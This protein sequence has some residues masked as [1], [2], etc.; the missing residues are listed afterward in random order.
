MPAPIAAFKVSPERLLD[1]A[2]ASLDL[3]RAP[4][5]ADLRADLS[6]VG[7]EGVRFTFELEDAV[8]ALST[9]RADQLQ[10][11][12]ALDEERE[13]DRLLAE[14]GFRWLSRL[15][16]RARLAAAGGADPEGIFPHRLGYRALPRARGA[17]VE[18]ELARVLPELDGLAAILAP[19]G[20]DAGFVEEGRQLS[21]GLQRARARTA[22][23]A[24]RRK[25]ATT[26]VRGAEQ[27]L[28]TAL[29]RLVAADEATCLER[30]GRRRAFP[31]TLLLPGR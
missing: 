27:A 29:R 2:R 7:L 4:E 25:T 17:G 3:L 10:L 16:A 6:S 22:T 30:P 23:V 12:A 15:H 20:L 9:A 31:L 8:L 18:A 28:I 5:N 1:Q 26:A 19:H 14:E 21:R 13:Q 11:S 24:D